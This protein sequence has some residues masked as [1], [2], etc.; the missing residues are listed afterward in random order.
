MFDG[1]PKRKLVEVDLEFDFV[2]LCSDKEVKFD[3][4]MINR[5]LGDLGICSE[6]EKQKFIHSLD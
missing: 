4:L 5:G 1:F 2:L 3:E 6:C